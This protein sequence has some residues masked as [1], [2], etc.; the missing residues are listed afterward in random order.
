MGEG[1]GGGARGSRVGTCACI[2]DVH[3]G[4]V[5]VCALIRVV[6]VYTYVWMACM[7]V[8]K[9]QEDWMTVQC[10]YKVSSRKNLKGW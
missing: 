4:G 6:S 7:C 5:F 3:V 9:L 8:V 1:G 10:R 2:I